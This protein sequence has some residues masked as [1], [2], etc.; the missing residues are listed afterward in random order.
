MNKMRE[1]MSGAV[2]KQ[3]ALSLVEQIYELELKRDQLSNESK[4][5]SYT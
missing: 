5:L 4:N 2:I 1:Q 3:E